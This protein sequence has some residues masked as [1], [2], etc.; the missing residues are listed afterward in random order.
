MSETTLELCIGDIL[1]LSF[2]HGGFGTL[3]TV[4]A[5]YALVVIAFAR[6]PLLPW[7]RVQFPIVGAVLCAAWGIA[8]ATLNGISLSQISITEFKLVV[9]GEIASQVVCCF[10]LVDFLLQERRAITSARP[11]NGPSHPPTPHPSH[12]VIIKQTHQPDHT[13]SHKQAPSDEYRGVPENPAN[14]PNRPRRREHTTRPPPT[15]PPSFAPSLFLLTLALLTSTSLNLYALFSLRPLAPPDPT[16][17]LTLVFTIGGL[18]LTIGLGVVPLPFAMRARR[19]RGEGGGG[20]TTLVDAFL[21]MSYVR[22]WLLWSLVVLAF[23]VRVWVDWM[24]VCLAG[25]DWGG[26][27]EGGLWVWVYVGAG[28]VLFLVF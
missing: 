4:L 2:P 26:F 1:G 25:E 20:L 28:K 19:S 8:C 24:A 22:V 16:K 11:H 3:N 23:V 18:L 27:G 6:S 12:R 14:N 21:G 13:Q 10:I 5:L 7:R 17:I 15:P 9:A